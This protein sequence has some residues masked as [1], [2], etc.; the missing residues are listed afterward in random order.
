MIRSSVLVLTLAACTLW[1]PAVRSSPPETVPSLAVRELD[2]ASYVELVRQW[3]TWIEDE[4]ESVEALVNLGK[5]LEYSG[6]R[7]AAM[8]AARRAVD[9][10]PDD[11]RALAFL[12]RVLLTG[13]GDVE[14]ALDLLERARRLA[15]DVPNTLSLIATAHLR[16]GRPHEAAE[17]LAVMHDRGMF[18]RPLL[19]L[20]HNFLVDLP[21][22]AILITSGDNDTYPVLGLQAARSFREDVTVVNRSLLNDPDYVGG[23]FAARPSIAVEMDYEGFEPFTDEDGI[24]HFLSR[25]LLLRMIAVADVPVHIALTAKYEIHGF[26]PEGEL[27]GMSFRASGD[28]RGPEVIAQALL[29]KARLDSATD[30]SF[31]WS[32]HPSLVPLMGN[33][34]NAMIR[35]A[36]MG[37][38][39][40]GTWEAL[41]EKAEG[42]AAFH[43]L[44]RQMTMIHRMRERRAA[45]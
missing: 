20:A 40:D 36:S 29:S 9:I 35:L 2:K 1:S 24:A 37:G 5:A 14:T 41:L 23:I 4:G 6:E 8:R 11:P 3:R 13:E 42:I 12:G 21:E 38:L 31:A 15:P 32:L 7:T 17:T 27:D 44:D 30:W 33:Y 45:E 10:G 43:D 28:A 26:E 19:D 22:G 25:E 34:V 18:V 39:S 16:A